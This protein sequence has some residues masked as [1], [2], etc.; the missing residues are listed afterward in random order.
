MASFT[1]TE[2]GATAD[3]SSRR[4]HQLMVASSLGFQL[5]IWPFAALSFSCRL[6]LAYRG[7]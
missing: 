4:V 6:G 1:A 7:K 5:L 2:V 3:A